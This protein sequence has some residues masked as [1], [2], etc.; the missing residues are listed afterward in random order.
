MNLLD[1]L[2]SCRDG[3]FVS[4]RNFD[5]NQS[6]HE[7]GYNLYYEDGANLSANGGLKFLMQED[8]AKDGWYVKY[9]KDQIDIHKLVDLHEHSNGLMISY[10]GKSYED[11]II[12]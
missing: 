2:Q 7:Y 1:A 3:N 9:T 11:C 8:W 4:H 6:M 12:K 5:S 10:Y